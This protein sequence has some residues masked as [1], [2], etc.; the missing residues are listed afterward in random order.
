MAVALG[1]VLVV[2]WQRSLEEVRQDTF[3]RTAQAVASRYGQLLGEFEQSSAAFASGPAVLSALQDPGGPR[4]SLR[5]VLEH[6]ALRE[7]FSSRILVVDAAGDPIAGVLSELPGDDI[8]GLLPG[9]IPAGDVTTRV[10]LDGRRLTLSLPVVGPE[11]GIA[12]G[13]L[14]AVVDLDDLFMPVMRGLP[15]AAQWTLQVGTGTPATLQGVG[16]IDIPVPT[17]GALRGIKLHLQAHRDGA[18]G[19][20]WGSLET[21]LLVLSGGLA[22]AALP[23]LRRLRAAT[24]VLPDGTGFRAPGQVSAIA[25]QDPAVARLSAVQADVTELIET[26]N[27]LRTKEARLSL[28][29]ALSPDGMA[30]MDA[31]GRVFMANEAFLRFVRL[32]RDQVIGH[33]APELSALLE[34]LAAPDEAWEGLP[35]PLDAASFVDDDPHRRRQSKRHRLHLVDPKQVL[36]CGVKPIPGLASREYVLY[37]RDITREHEF[38]E[39]KSEFLSTATHELRTPMA[40]VLG[41][42]EMLAEGL[43]TAEDTPEHAR[44]IYEQAREMSRT[45]DDLLDLARME[46]RRAGSLTFVPESAVAIVTGLAQTWRV[47]GDSRSVQL[48]VACDAD[49]CVSVDTQKIRQVLRN[50]L[51]NAFKYS[52]APSPVSLSVQAGPDGPVLFTVTDEGMGMTPDEAQHA[53]DRFYRAEGTSNVKGSGLGLSVVKQIVELH[54]GT[55]RLSSLVGTGTVVSVELPRIPGTRGEAGALDDDRPGFDEAQDRPGPG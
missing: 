15:E 12:V 40:C 48:Q 26:A 47:N 29:F 28:M 7:R 4:S 24:R 51:S 16:W 42:A 34:P 41:F 30:L 37:M 6:S 53:F 38:N 8:R 49:V 5:A 44:L 54:G 22:L 36:V 23:I 50:L 19:L 39:M 33:T 35:S 46:A 3:E 52:T 32:G 14:L 31:D 55:V 27:E 21:V 25:D 43:S 9:P 11:A 13:R 2:L 1:L 18:G 10:V 20:P 45:L 17:D